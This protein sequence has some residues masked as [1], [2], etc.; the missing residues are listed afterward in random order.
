MKQQKQNRPIDKT[1]RLC[2][3]FA[4]RIGIAAHSPTRRRPTLPHTDG[5]P[6]RQS[7]ML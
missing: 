2:S 3:N 6:P 1:T 4:G 5:Q 7:I